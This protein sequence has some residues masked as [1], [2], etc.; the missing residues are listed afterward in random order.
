MTAD[1]PAWGEV[2]SRL[3]DVLDLP[4]AERGALLRTY[5]PP[6]REAVRSL[7]GAH[8][9]V[10]GVLD[11]VPDDRGDAIRSIAETLR[12]DPLVGERIG[13]WRVRARLGQGGMGTVYRAERADGLFDREVALKVVRARFARGPAAEALQRR[14]EAERRLLASLDHPG[15]A[16]LFDGGTLEDGRPWLAMELVEGEPLTDWAERH[17]LDASARLALFVDTLD[18][19]AHAHRHLVVHCDLKPSHIVVE[20][21]DD[22]RPRVCVLD[23]GIAAALGTG[24]REPSGAASPPPEASG[25]ASSPD[26]AAGPHTTEYAA[27]EQIAGGPVTTSADV[28]ALGVV[29]FE[30]LAG[31]R[32][33]REASGAVTESLS[34][35]AAPDRQ[36]RLRGDLDAI[37]ARALT[38]DPERR[39]PS[40]EAFAADLRRHLRHEPV[41]ARPASAL[42][43]ASRFV[44]RHR[45]SVAASGVVLGAL[46]AFGWYHTASVTAERNAARREAA[47]ASA[48]AS[49]LTDVFRTYNPDAEIGD[50]VSARALLDARVARLRTAPD[51]PATPALLDAAA[52][53]YA[54]LAL[55]DEA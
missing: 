10:G 53:A 46:L 20:A 37:L 3:A 35:A 27:P 55:Y 49:F 50:R 25:V 21:D 5:A 40:A 6:M 12:D 41:A 26:P 23:F 48:T 32:P 44:R 18:A 24:G 14:F 9:T 15:I 19:L 17:A 31:R 22:G 42:Y 1:A 45:V 13:P 4:E 36:R 2:K 11:D 52:R 16:R 34:G 47:K 30:L 8:D 29:L 28:F 43:R 51:D 39:Y 7:L 54:G 38:H 33:Q